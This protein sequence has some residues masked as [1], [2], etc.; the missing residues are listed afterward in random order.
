[1]K[2]L[3]YEIICDKC[4]NAINHYPGW[5]P[6]RKTLMK[7]KIITVLSYAEKDRH[8]CVECVEKLGISYAK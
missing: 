3:I 1:M 6:N 8:Y 2:K 5:S 7:D 4:G